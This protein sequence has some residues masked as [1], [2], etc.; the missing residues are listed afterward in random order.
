MKMAR[1]RILISCMIIVL[2]LS[3]AGCTGES[4]PGKGGK[5]KVGFLL[6]MSGGLADKGRDCVSAAKLAVD[7]INAA[8]GIKALG[9][10]I[11]EPVFGDTEGNPDRGSR[12]AERLIGE[13]GVVALVGTYQSSVTKAATQVAERLKTP[14]VVNVSIA[15]LI[16]ERGFRYTFRIQ[17]K[18]RFYARDQAQFLVDLQGF[19]GHRVKRVA[20]LH[21]NTDFGTSTALAQKKALREQNLEVVIEVSYVAEGIVDL[22]REVAQVLAAKPDAILEVTYLKDSILIRRALA[23]AGAAIPL[24]DTAGGTVSPEYIVELGQLSEGTFTSSEYSK[25][26]P[27][28]KE[29]NDRFRA[30]FGV[31]ITGDSAY[32]YQAVLV[33]KDALE[34]A[35]STEKEALRRALADTDMPRGPGMILP[36][37]RLRFDESG[38]NEFG[39]LFVVQIQNGE[40]MPVWPPQYAAAKVRLRR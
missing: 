4:R 37:E 30:R 32:T 28:A 27:G 19:T 26:A 29:L 7:E 13:Q 6:P 38:Q 14:F 2:L 5:I 20:L 35:R 33:V 10:A 24:V 31:D 1:T 18:A 16:T 39:N 21:E 22:T 23:Q 17:P 8:G 15:D 12:E 34:R 9:G 3:V 36:A 25:Y 11:L 40:L